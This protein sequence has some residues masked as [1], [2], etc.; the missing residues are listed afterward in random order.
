MKESL[1]LSRSLLFCLI[2]AGLMGCTTIKRMGLNDLTPTSETREVTLK[3][4]AKTCQYEGP[5]IITSG[6]LTVS[7]MNESDY[8]AS[9]WMVKI[10][11]GKTW[12]DLL[13]YI[14]APGSNV[15]PPPWTSP[16]IITTTSRDSPNVKIYTLNPG[17]YAICCC[18]C[19]EITGP[20]GVWPGAPVEVKDDNSSD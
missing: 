7:L 19:N 2:V 3:F 9:I 6:D 16:S 4:D 15:H 14:G 12:Q 18:T 5:E 17:L 10:D 11:E 20:R 13:D 8:D 1:F